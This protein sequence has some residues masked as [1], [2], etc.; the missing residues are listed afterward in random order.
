MKQRVLVGSALMI[1]LCGLARAQS[2]SG[3]AADP[4]AIKREVLK[5]EQEQDEAVAKSDVKVLDRIWADGLVYTT[6]TGELVTKA[7]HLADFRSGVRKFD[8]MKHDNFHVRVYG[9]TAV[10]TARSTSTLHYKG[11]VSVGPRVF[12]NVYVKMDGRWQLVSHHV[13]DVAKP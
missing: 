1:A 4:E 6:P 12:T 5:V 2:P 13:T 3:E 11:Q 10:L 7:Q 9:D 8:T